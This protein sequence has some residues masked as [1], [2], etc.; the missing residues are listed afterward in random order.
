MKLGELKPAKGA[1][2]K[3][4]RV[5]CGSGSGHGKTSCRGQKGQRSRSGSSKKPW[6]EGGQMPLQRRVP[7]RG[8][9][10]VFKTIYE[11][12]NIEDLKRFPA[13]T[14]VDA[15]NLREAGLISKRKARVK[16]LGGGEIDRPMKIKVHACSKSARE[17]VEKAGGQVQI[18]ER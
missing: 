2:K 6:F 11:I 10:N 5:G 3:R 16:L 17:R 8:F 1:K 14:E 4:K 13:D 18:V 15:K 7:K 12:V 9:H